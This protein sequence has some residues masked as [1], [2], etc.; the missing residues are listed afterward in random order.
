[1]HS[2]KKANQWYF[3]MKAHIGVD[4]ELG[5]VHMVKGT[6][7]HVHDINEGNALL[8]GRI[9]YPDCGPLAQASSYFSSSLNEVWC[10]KTCYSTKKVVNRS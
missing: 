6:A 10:A 5:L 9:P 3:G 7:G 8:P 1:M 2:N 4:A